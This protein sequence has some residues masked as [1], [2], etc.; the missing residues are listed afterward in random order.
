[1]REA[2]RTS[3]EGGSQVLT[4]G[5]LWA[6]EESAGPAAEQTGRRKRQRRAEG[7]VGGC[8]RATGVLPIGGGLQAAALWQREASARGSAA[9][10]GW[11]WKAGAGSGAGGWGSTRAGQCQR[12]GRRA[13]CRWRTP[14][15]RAMESTDGGGSSS[16]RGAPCRWRRAAGGVRRTWNFLF[17]VGPSFIP[18]LKILDSSQERTSYK[19]LLCA[20]YRPLL[21]MTQSVPKRKA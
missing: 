15:G 12:W 18:R 20:N 7:T 6:E 1:M 13:A 21:E 19:P 17:Q 4:R 16:V 2:A 11:R 3:W 5:P 9:G 8:G 14:S 10:G